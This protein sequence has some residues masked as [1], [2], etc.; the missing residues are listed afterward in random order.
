MRIAH[1]DQDVARAYV[2]GFG[3]DFVGRVE[4][5]LLVLVPGDVRGQFVLFVVIALG[6]FEYAEKSDRKGEAGDGGDL[7]WSPR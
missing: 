4:A 7:L 6:E 5:K 1:R 2:Q 3:G